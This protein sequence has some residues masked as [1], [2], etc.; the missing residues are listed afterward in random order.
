[1]FITIAV[2]FIVLA[3]FLLIIYNM[4]SDYLSKKEA[5]MRMMVNRARNIVSDTEDLIVNQAQLPLSKTMV[6]ILRYRMLSALKIM[7]QDKSLKNV[8]EKI[9]DQEKH[10]RDVKANYKEDIAFRAPE[11]DTLA[12]AQLR[13]IRKLRKIVAL[14]IRAGTP[15]DIGE[16][17]KEDSRLNML[18]LKVNISNVIQNVLEL[19]RLHQIGSCRQLIDKGIEVI[20]KSGSKDPWI[21]EKLEILSQLK[22]DIDKDVKAKGAQQTQKMIESDEEKEEK[23]SEIEALFADKKKW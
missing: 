10:I 14:E 21:Q 6:L 15:V 19:R 11:N 18:V 20:R 3:T 13:M 9:Q 8:L 2:I 16:C 5:D 23:N 22:R 17:Q 7:K 12:V 4:Y 1:M